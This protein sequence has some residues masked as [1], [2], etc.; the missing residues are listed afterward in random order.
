MD[1]LYSIICNLSYGSTDCGDNDSRASVFTRVD[2]YLKWV[3]RGAKD[4]ECEANRLE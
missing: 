3:V 4:G 2:A 1:E